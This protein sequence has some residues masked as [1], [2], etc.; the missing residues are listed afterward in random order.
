MLD[1]SHDQQ[2]SFKWSLLASFKTLIL[3]ATFHKFCYVSHSFYSIKSVT[4]LVR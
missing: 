4:A 3:E 2:M 1:S